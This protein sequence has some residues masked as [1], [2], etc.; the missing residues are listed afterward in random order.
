MPLCPKNP[1]PGPE[2]LQGWPCCGNLAAVLW[3]PLGPLQ[4]LSPPP[5]PAAL[6]LLKSAIEKAGYP[7]KVVIGMDVAASEF[8]RNGKYDLDFKSPDDPSR[9]ITGEKLGELYQSFIKNYP[10]E[11]RVPG[12][13]HSLRALPWEVCLQLTLGCDKGPS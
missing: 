12:P 9:H 4:F 6:E 13:S 10:G 3:V 8:F 2:G 7:D 1:S 11:R 5:P